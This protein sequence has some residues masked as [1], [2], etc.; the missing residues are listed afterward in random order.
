M[1]PPR[2][3]VAVLD[4]GHKIR[5]PDA[6]ITLAAKQLQTVHR[7]V[8]SG[9]PIQ[10]RLQEMWSLFDF[11]FPGKLGTLPVFT[12][13]FAIPITVG[14]YV[15]ASTLQARRGMLVQAAYRCAVVLRDLISPYLLR[16]LK[17]DVLGDSLPQKTEQAR[18]V[19]RADRGAARAVPRLPG[20]W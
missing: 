6:D 18:P 11:I 16:R 9:S 12:A 14:G 19:L 2:W 13:Q 10:N 17:K 7:L 5:N 15:N 3:G 4:E 1:L 20:V 8:L